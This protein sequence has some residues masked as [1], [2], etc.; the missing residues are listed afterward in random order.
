M[1]C[2]G[3]AGARAMCGGAY[4]NTVLDIRELVYPNVADE[5]IYEGC[6]KDWASQ[7]GPVHLGKISDVKECFGLALKYGFSYVGLRGQE[8]LGAKATVHVD[9]SKLD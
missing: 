9:K 2:A 5:P 8:C 3:G 7:A 6:V 1:N 4:R